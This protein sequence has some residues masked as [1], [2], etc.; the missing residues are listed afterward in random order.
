MNIINRYNKLNVWNKLAVW[1]AL[2][3][4]VGIILVVSAKNENKG[5]VSVTNSPN[6]IVQSMVDSP[7][8]TQ[9][10]IS[11]KK[12]IQLNDNIKKQLDD[13]LINDKGKE[14]LVLYE[15]SDS[16]AINLA[17]EIRDY[18]KLKGHS[19]KGFGQRMSNNPSK[20][21]GIID[22]PDGSIDLVIG[23]LE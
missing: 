4:I 2:A 3:S 21:I 10:N 16:E 9:I 17:K 23:I 15:A 5:N 13:Q 7:N 22:N 1:G 14:I 20:G 11:Q 12:K 8:A 19:I 18:L 6:T